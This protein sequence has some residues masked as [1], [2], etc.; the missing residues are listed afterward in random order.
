VE[1][2]KANLTMEKNEASMKFVEL[3]KRRFPK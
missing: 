1:F 3:L 2:L